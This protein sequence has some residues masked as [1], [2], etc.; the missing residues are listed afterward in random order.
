MTELTRSELIAV[1]QGLFGREPES[2]AVFDTFCVEGNTIDRMIRLA[3]AS[4]EFAVRFAHRPFQSVRGSFAHNGDRFL[5]PVDLR[6]EI[7]LPPRILLVGSS[8]LDHWVTAIQ[9]SETNL[10]ADRVDIDH[11]PTLSPPHPWDQYRYQVVHV[12]LAVLFPDELY[13]SWVKTGYADSTAASS[14]FRIVRAALTKWLQRLQEWSNHCPVFVMNFLQPMT[15]VNGRFVRTNDFRDLKYFVGKLNQELDSLVG[16]LPDV[17][18]LDVDGCAANIGRRYFQGDMVCSCN[19]GGVIF[20]SEL[21]EDTGLEPRLQPIT[22]HYK[23]EQQR[24]V[25]GCLL[26][27]D[28]TYRSL[29]DLGLVK[30]V[31]VDLDDTLWRRTV[32]Q[33]EPLDAAKAIN[34]WPLGIIEALAVLKRRGI[35]ICLLGS[36]DEEAVRTMWGK[37]YGHLMPLSEFTVVKLGGESKTKKIESALNDSGIAASDAVLFDNEGG[38]PQIT[39]VLPDLRII[40]VSHYY[41][42]RV[43]L[44]SA[45][46]QPRSITGNSASHSSGSESS[47][48]ITRNRASPVSSEVTSSQTLSRRS[49][50]Q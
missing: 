4:E 17:H 34:G 46:T 30:M 1:F 9:H 24:F 36:S 31:C 28:A 20:S 42:K 47:A 50:I 7:D 49:R 40:N 12:P 16:G 27:A 18:V 21:D 35:L 5:A 29:H 10:V 45:E 22:S 15:G 33:Q 11:H 39:S 32:A 8:V 14:I 43:L 6:R 38:N 25:T 19:Q 37:L 13:L 44:W 3:I 23:L 2:E 48:D 41:W 26:E